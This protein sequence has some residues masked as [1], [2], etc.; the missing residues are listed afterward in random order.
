MEEVATAARTSPPDWQKQLR[1]TLP[2]LEED[3]RGAK[4][5]IFGCKGWGR[6]MERQRCSGQDRRQPLVVQ[7]WPSESDWTTTTHNQRCR[8]VGRAQWVGSAGH[9]LGGCSPGLHGQASAGEAAVP[10]QREHG[11]PGK[12]LQ[13]DPL[14]L[15]WGWAPQ[16]LPRLFKDLRS[17]AWGPGLDRASVAQLWAQETTHSTGISTWITKSLASGGVLFHFSK[18]KKTSGI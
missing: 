10:A 15:F 6:G 18:I 9:T 14:T 16:E 1:N 12:E 4:N 8:D 11:D 7:L 2:Q 3:N 5:R 17:R 13:G